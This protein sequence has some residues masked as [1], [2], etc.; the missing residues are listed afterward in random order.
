LEAPGSLN[1]Y[2]PGAVS[3]TV[4]SVSQSLGGLK[5]SVR[6]NALKANPGLF[7]KVNWNVPFATLNPPVK[8]I[9]KTPRL[10]VLALLGVPFTEA[11]TNAEPTPT[12]LTAVEVNEVAV[13]FDACRDNTWL[14]STVNTQN[15]VPESGLSRLAP[16]K[17]RGIGRK[18]HGG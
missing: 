9:G 2:W 16:G 1:W 18:P 11:V 13:Q 12:P 8:T 6:T 3:V 4:P 15:S 5:I 14:F 7:V 17:S 10:M